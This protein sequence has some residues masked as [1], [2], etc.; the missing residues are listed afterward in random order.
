MQHTH[1]DQKDKTAPKILPEKIHSKNNSNYNTINQSVEIPLK[2]TQPKEKEI[3]PKKEI[4]LQKGDRLKS[5]SK[6]VKNHKISAKENKNKVDKKEN[7]KITTLSYN[8]NTTTSS[9]NPKSINMNAK[10]SLETKRLSLPLSKEKIKKISTVLPEKKNQKL[11]SIE[12]NLN[13]DQ[14]PIK[15]VSVATEEMIRENLQKN[16]NKD[17]TLALEN[18]NISSG[19]HLESQENQTTELKIDDYKTQLDVEPVD[20]D[21]V[22]TSF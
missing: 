1:R 12:I 13:C 22:E 3:I 16:E 2:K 7:I 15:I 19:N 9:N 8:T 4:D 5:R 11:Q 6:D 14:E 20:T 18:L 10:S 21:M 17:L